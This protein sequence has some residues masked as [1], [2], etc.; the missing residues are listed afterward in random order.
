VSIPETW[1]ER[2][3]ALAPILFATTSIPKLLQARLVLSG[4]GFEVQRLEAHSRAYTEPYG[5]PD[6]AFLQAGIDEI[7]AR[8]GGHRLMFID[9]TTVTFP[10]LSS[11][12]EPVPGRRTKEWFAET[13]HGELL[14]QLDRAG[15]SRSVVVRSDLALY[16][17]G[18]ADA[19]VF[20]SPTEGKV[21]EALEPVAPNR[22]YPWLGQ[23]DFSSWFIPNGASRV[24][25]SMRLEESMRYDFRTAALNMMAER[26]TEYLAIINLPLASIRA[27]QPNGGFDP[28]QLTLFDVGDERSLFVVVGRMAAGKTTV[29]HYLELYRHFRHIEGSR[30][31]VLVGHKHDIWHTSSNFEL[32]DRLFA[33]FGY[34]VVE[35]EFVLP[36]LSF[37]DGPIVYTG[38]RTV[39]GLA[40]LKQAARDLGWRVYVVY[41]ASPSNLRLSRAVERARTD[42]ALDP[43]QFESSSLRDEAYGAARFGQLAADVILRNSG[44]LQNLL[45]SID[46]AV[47]KLR[48]PG[49]GQVGARGMRAKLAAARS[50]ADAISLVAKVAPDAGKEMGLE[51]LVSLADALYS[52]IST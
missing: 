31:L 46:R 45:R 32:A 6:R 12:G 16:V 51:R 30:A 8:A 29:G 24:L 10:S 50:A 38:C 52:L 5:E 14:R 25:G 18:L 40:T 7:R 22:L 47:L 4:H 1:V 39:E 23:P 41:V 48:R 49:P 21:A 19:I 13:T 20:S 35:R 3:T 2:L 43:M 42:V 26:L 36:Q 33:G 11:P 34:D 44:D 17:P 37:S 15:G 28:L 27:Q 9:D